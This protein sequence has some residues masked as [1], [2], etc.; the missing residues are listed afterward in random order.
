MNSP[1]FVFDRA[2]AILERLKS[3][4]NTRESLKALTEETLMRLRAAIDGDTPLP[5]PVEPTAFEDWSEDLS[6]ARGYE[7]DPVKK[8]L[9]ILASPGPTHETVA[10]IF[11]EWFVELRKASQQKVKMRVKGAQ[12]VF[13]KSNI[14]ALLTY[15][16][17]GCRLKDGSIMA[18]DG[19]ISLGIRGPVIVIEVGVSQDFNKLV[20]KAEKW[21][22]RSRP[23]RLVILVDIN[24]IKLGTTNHSSLL[25]SSA[26]STLGSQEALPYGI[27]KQE[28]ENIDFEEIGLKIFNW[29]EDKTALAKLKDVNLYLYRRRPGSHPAISQDA[30]IVIFEE[31]SGFTNLESV[32]AF[33]TTDDLEITTGDQAEKVPL[34]LGPL[35][36]CFDQ[37]LA[38]EEQLETAKTKARQILESL[39]YEGEASSFQPSTGTGEGPSDLHNEESDRPQRQTRQRKR[40]LNNSGDVTTDPDSSFGPTQSFQ[41][42]GSGLFPMDPLGSSDAPQYSQRS[43]PFLSAVDSQPANAA[44]ASFS[45]AVGS[46]SSISQHQ[47]K[48]LKGKNRKKKG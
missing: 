2:E 3:G 40:K 45:S 24:I 7:Y 16:V 26:S 48:R 1:S 4:S 32:E 38:E 9:I 34:P 6:D 35:Q 47:P 29:Y 20:K 8:E 33:I 17:I 13:R 46:E 43:S 37:T 44:L 41:T 31:H 19:S 11:N 23:T 39:G 14:R 42:T 12:G 21:L 30:K 28:L 36:A 5:F 10:Q 15:F 27:T 25:T 22:L 18:S